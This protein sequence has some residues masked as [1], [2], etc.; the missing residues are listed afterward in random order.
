FLR[1]ACLAR[2]TARQ[3]RHA[4]AG[5]L[6]DAALEAFA[7]EG[8]AAVGGEAQRVDELAVDVLV[9]QRAVRLLAFLR[10]RR[11]RAEEAMVGETRIGT[12]ERMT[13]VAGPGILARLLRQLGAHGVRLDVPAAI[14]QM[15]G[16]LDRR[17]A[18]APLPQ[19]ARPSALAVD[20]ACVAASQRLQ[21]A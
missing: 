19:R 14:D 21:R 3:R 15:E 6:G 4:A 10:P 2:A 12:P 17:R 5:R 20:V 7:A 13:V 11:Q 18:V 16:S 9:E 1:R 8:P